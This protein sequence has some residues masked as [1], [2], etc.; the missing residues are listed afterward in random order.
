MK[1]IIFN[2]LQEVVAKEHGEATWDAL[3]EGSGVSGAYSSL[4]NYPDEELGRIVGTASKALQI[5]PQDIIR[6]FGRNAIPLLA[7]H[8]P[9]FFSPHTRT[10]DFLLTLNT[11][12]HPEVRK[13][14]PNAD[15]P[16]FDFESPSDDVLHLGYRSHRKLCALAE[17]FV[18]GAA[19][20]FGEN[21]ALEQ[22]QCMNRGDERCLI[23]AR[24]SPGG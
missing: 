19:A 10:S 16:E 2:L 9:Q 14:Y 17:G 15:V 7:V 12:I 13:L 3:I 22:T 24:F 21:V 5:P 6:W 1:G 20:H 8:Y 23:V 11:I 4:G 18:E